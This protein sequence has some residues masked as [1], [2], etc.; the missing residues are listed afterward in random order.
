MLLPRIRVQ[1]CHHRVTVVAREEFEAPPG[2]EGRPVI[3][4]SQRFVFEMADA[5]AVFG[6]DVAVSA[7]LVLV[8]G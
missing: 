2:D 1:S 7:E 3:L 6:N 4:L 5:A 8:G